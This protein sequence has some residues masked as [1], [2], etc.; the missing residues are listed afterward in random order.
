M[1]ILGHGGIIELSREWPP[2]LALSN[3]AYKLNSKLIDIGVDAYWTGDKLQFS[4]ANGIPVDLNGDGYADC[5]EGHGI[6][7]GSIYQLGPARDFYKGPETNENGPHYQV[8]S[9]ALA[10]SQINYELSPTSLT[11]N[12]PNFVTGDKV[13]FSTALGFPIDF[14]G[15]TYPDTPDGLGFYFG[16]YWI[17]GPSRLHVTSSGDPFLPRFRCRRLLPGRSRH[18]A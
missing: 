18:G 13:W 9:L 6:Y 11:I 12:H 7:R 10:P 8:A 16:S 17:L 4:S 15:D 3:E 5:P 14:N 2:P 1:P